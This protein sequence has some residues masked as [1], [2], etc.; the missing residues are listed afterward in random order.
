MS[1]IKPRLLDA[2]GNIVRTIDPVSLSLD[3][4]L[5]PLSSAEMELVPGDELP[6]R[7]W[8]AIYTPY[9]LAGVFRSQPPRERYGDRSVTVQLDHGLAE[10][11]DYIVTGEIEQTETSGGAAI[12]SIF[13]NYRGTKWQLGTVTNA[14]NIVF[15]EKSHS[16][17]LDAILS[18]MSKTPDY[19]LTCDQTTTPWTLNVVAKP[20]TVSCEGRISRNIESLEITTDESEMCNRVYIDGVT[21]YIEDTAARAAHGGVIEHHLSESDLTQD[22]AYIVASLYLEQHKRPRYSVSISAIDLSEATGE[23]LDQIRL[24]AKYRLTIPED[25]VLIEE[26][27]TSI[28][29]SNLLGNPDNQQI[30]IA[31]RE[32]DVIEFLKRQRGSGRS[33]QEAIEEINSQYQHFHEE[34]EIYKSDTYK[35]LGVKI[36]DMGQVAYEVERDAQGNVIY[37]EDGVTPVYKR[38]AAG[39]KIPVFDP[40]ATG[41]LSGKITQTAQNYESLYTLTGVSSLGNEETLYSRIAQNAWGIQQTVSQSGTV[42]AVFDPEKAGGYSKGDKVLYNGVPYQF[43]ADHTGAWTGEDVKRVYDLQS[44]ITQSAGEISSLVTKTGV[45]ELGDTETLYSKISQEADSISLVV[46]EKVVE[47]QTVKYVKRA[48][49][50]AAINDDD[51]STV[52]ISADEIDLSGYVTADELFVDGSVSAQKTIY[53]GGLHVYEDAEIDGNITMSSDSDISTGTI[54]A[55][56]LIEANFGID[57]TNGVETD[58]LVTGTLTV[59][60]EAY[61]GKSVSIAGTTVQN[62]Y[63][64]GTGNIEIPDAITNIQIV[65]PGTG[66]NTYTIQKKTLSN[67]SWTDVGTFSRATSLSG[68]WSGRGTYTV[69]ATPQNESTSTTLH[70]IVSNG[71]PTKNSTLAKYLNVPLKV[72]YD[73][74][75]ATNDAK[76]STGFTE[77]ISVNASLIF[78]DGQDSCV[79]NNLSG[80]TAIASNVLKPTVS[81]TASGANLTDYSENVTLERNTYTVGQTTNHCVNLLMDSTIVGR[82]STE[83]VYTDGKSDG[84]DSVSAILAET[85]NTSAVPS[86][87]E[88]TSGRTYHIYRVVDGLRDITALAT[89]SVPAATEPGAI[90][91]LSASTLATNQILETIS[92]TASGTNVSSYSESV[93][94]EKGTYA[95]GQLTN[96]CVNLK[97]DNAVVG[98]ISTESVYLDGR[99]YGFGICHD[100]IDL[101]ASS[102]TLA[103]GGSVT[104]YPKAKASATASSATNITTKGITI[105][106]AAAPSA[107]VDSITITPDNQATDPS[108][109]VNPGGVT[110]DAK[111]SSASVVGS[112]YAYLY[113]TTGSWNTSGSNKGRMAVNIRLDSSGGKLIARKWVGC[114]VGTPYMNQPAQGKIRAVCEV[115]GITYYGNTHNVSEYS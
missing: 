46:G 105:T 22:Q 33:A 60:D 3:L 27:I 100:S 1:V 90:T 28:R 8:V 14:T 18:V 67:T 7:S 41:S 58:T 64:L 89:Y 85:V 29:Y 54:T 34:N 73:D 102:Q 47:G 19:M 10:L 51:T 24:G 76:P 36:N 39:N 61:E 62:L 35:I 32:D 44:Q 92:I 113:I 49:I 111:D 110:L 106:A 2:S 16:G 80:G 38:D 86:G 9:G 55:E 87:T 48:G 101:S 6:A 97:M 77:T 11:N 13:A 50:V 82:I 21:P 112:D 71:T 93:T 63:V 81:I 57:V 45:N 78:E 108:Y 103:A 84:Q 104:I 53:A 70:G 26:V 88:L 42:T 114:N 98:R 59:D 4:E 23:A 115:N 56:G 40:D 75:D 43:T 109:D 91:D 96:H 72:T 25:G 83:S 31:E 79:I 52:K 17:V 69:N 68:G 12:R 37:E 15:E 65:P 20:D 74:G 107:S 99:D 5:S 30:T 94:L 66:S 95:V